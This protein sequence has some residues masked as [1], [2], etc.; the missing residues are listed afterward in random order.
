MTN[1]YDSFFPGPNTK[2]F[3]SDVV[4]YAFQTIFSDTD[5]CVVVNDLKRNINF[6]HPT[7]TVDSSM[8]NMESSK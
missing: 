7:L 5:K 1:K 8:L 4:D 3:I 2:D 6:N